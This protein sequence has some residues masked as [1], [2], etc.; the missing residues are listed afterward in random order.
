MIDGTHLA[1]S[2][3]SGNITDQFCSLGLVSLKI[4][5]FQ[6]LNNGLHN[7]ICR[8]NPNSEFK[9]DDL[10]TS[11]SSDKAIRLINFVFENLDKLKIDVIIWDHSD[12]RHDQWAPIDDCKNRAIMYFNL[13]LNTFSRR[14]SPDAKWLC[15]PDIQSMDCEL[16]SDFLNSKK[17]P[18][19]VPLFNAGEYRQL[20]AVDIAQNLNSKDHSLIQLADL[21][22]GMARY[23]YTQFENFF[24]W[25]RSENSKQELHRCPLLPGFEVHVEPITHLSNKQKW[26]FPVLKHFYE[27]CGTNRLGVSYEHSDSQGFK[28]WNPY[29]LS[30]RPFNFWFY[31]PQH[32]MDKAPLKVS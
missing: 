3:D 10:E 30:K 32:I 1:F 5:D 9:W 22:A 2:D 8:D 31:V 16:L 7:I 4:S 6:V 11:R 25:Q 20:S 26:R 19:N 29:Q 28:T 14:W 18:Q 13:M 17:I 23:S 21:F 12:S 15:Y 27:L 24:K